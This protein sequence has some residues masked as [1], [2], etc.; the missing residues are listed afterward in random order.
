MAN[1]AYDLTGLDLSI[2]LS[3]T[4]WKRKIEDYTVEENVVVFTLQGTDQVFTG[5]HRL[6][7]Y[8]NEGGEGQ[9]V[10]DTEAF[11]LVASSSEVSYDD[12]GSIEIEVV[13]L[14]STTEA[15]GYS[16]TATVERTETGAVVSVTDKNGT[17][18]A[19]IYDGEQ[20]EP[21]IGFDSV[22]SA[23]DG[24]AVITLSSGDTITLDLNH[25][26]SSKPNYVYCA[27]Q[28]EY[29]AIT[30]KDSGTLYLILDS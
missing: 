10:L 19:N 20:G 6:T 16:P 4:G 3:A 26:H 13:E 15:N 22:S 2:Y 27:S 11:I 12:T 21:G 1:N 23:Q 25:D 28:A 30:T 29:D 5:T 24:T 8:V 18:T 14:T 17:T 7:M 9:Q